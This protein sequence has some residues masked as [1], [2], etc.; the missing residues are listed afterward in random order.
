MMTGRGAKYRHSRVW[1]RAAMPRNPVAPSPPDCYWKP[2]GRHAHAGQG[3]LALILLACA[4]TCCISGRCR[5]AARPARVQC[6]F[7][8]PGS[9]RRAGRRSDLHRCLRRSRRRR[10]PPNSG[11]PPLAG[12]RFIILGGANVTMAQGSTDAAGEYCTGGLAPGRY[13]LREA[14]AAGAPGQPVTLSGTE[15]ARVAFGAR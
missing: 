11:E 12:R 7:D 13:S 3:Q 8:R 1:K 5:R 14:G 6:P 4:G 2:P 10:R 15:T 9:Q